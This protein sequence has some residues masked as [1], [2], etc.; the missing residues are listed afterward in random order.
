MAVNGPLARTV[1]DAALMFSVLVG[2]DP[3]DPLSLPATGEDWVEAGR[4]SDLAGLRVAWTP[5]LGGAAPVA[6]EVAEICAGAAARFAE[7]G[8]Q[9]HAV[10]PEVG[11]I[12]EPYLV[13]NSCLRQATVG[14]H[15]AEWREQMDPVLVERLEAGA[16]FTGADVGR[17]EVARSAYYQRLR[18]FFERFD[19]LLLPTTATAALPLDGRLPATLGGRPIRQG[20]DL[21][22][23]TYAFNLSGHPAISVPCGW[24]QTG[25][26]VGLQIVGGWRQDARVLRAAAAFEQIHPWRHRRPPLD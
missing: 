13:L 22:L 19:L 6:A 17:A 2:P 14:P 7:L 8:A 11:Q 20:L 9:L 1:L 25:L 23:F 4:G 26:P 16:R 15:L 10:D 3:R 5:D 21:Q 24:T 18:R 12:V